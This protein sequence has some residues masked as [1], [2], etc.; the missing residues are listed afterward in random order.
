MR[1]KTELEFPCAKLRLLLVEPA[2]RG[3]GLGRALIA[4]C[5]ELAREAE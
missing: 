1:D 5:T 3:M 2:V 4:R